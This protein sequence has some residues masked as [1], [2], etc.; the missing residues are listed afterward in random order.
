[1]IA[2]G[3]RRIFAMGNGAFNENHNMQLKTLFCKRKVAEAIIFLAINS[4]QAMRHKQRENGTKTREAEK[5]ANGK[6]ETGNRKQER[7][8][9][10]QE[11]GNRK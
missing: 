8:N 7:G 10:E 4:T 5:T 1:M 3:R 2:R 11:T 9:G 6:R